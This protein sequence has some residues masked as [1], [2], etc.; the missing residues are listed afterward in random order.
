MSVDQDSL[1]ECQADGQLSLENISN[2]SK[3]LETF[4]NCAF[5]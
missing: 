3:N 2:E 4:Q 1:S 5:D